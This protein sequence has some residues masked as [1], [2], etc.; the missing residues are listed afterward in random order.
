VEAARAAL[1]QSKSSGENNATTA[2]L[3]KGTRRTWII[4]N[5]NLLDSK[6]EYG[7]MDPGKRQLRDSHLPPKGSAQARPRALQLS[8]KKD[9][10]ADY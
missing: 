2:T 1:V 5:N 6:P 9:F 7:N 4:L 3:L 8:H 10:R